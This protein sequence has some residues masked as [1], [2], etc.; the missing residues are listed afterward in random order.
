MH[1]FPNNHSRSVHHFLLVK[2]SVPRQFWEISYEPAA[3]LA[4]YPVHCTQPGPQ[5]P[6]R[7]WRKKI[8]APS[9]YAAIINREVPKCR[10]ALS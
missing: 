4:S 2:L 5:L 8:I 10:K 6:L 7:T 9:L 1:Q 3:L